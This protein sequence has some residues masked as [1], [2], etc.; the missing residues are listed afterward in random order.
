MA[1]RALLWLMAAAL[2][3]APHVWRAAVEVNETAARRAAIWAAAG[4]PPAPTAAGVGVLAA[5]SRDAHMLIPPAGAEQERR[6]QLRRAADAD[7]VRTAPSI[8][9]TRG[10]TIREVRAR[11]KEWAAVARV[12]RQKAPCGGVTAAAPP[13]AASAAT[14]TAPPPSAGSAAPSPLPLTMVWPTEAKRWWSTELAPLPAPAP[15]PRPQHAQR[16]WSAPPGVGTARGAAHAAGGGARTRQSRRPQTAAGAGSRGA[17]PAW[18]RRSTELVAGSAGE[19]SRRSPLRAAPVTRD[20]PPPR[21]ECC[22]PHPQRGHTCVKGAAQGRGVLDGDAAVGAAGVPAAG[23]GG[24]RTLWPCGSRVATAAAT[25]GAGTCGEGPRRASDPLTPLTPLTP[26]TIGVAAPPSRAQGSALGGA[27]GGARSPPA[28]CAR[29]S[30]AC[31]YVHDE[32]ERKWAERKRRRVGATA[33]A[34]AAC[35]ATSAAAPEQP[36]VDSGKAAREKKRRKKEKKKEKKKKKK[37]KRKK[38]E[39]K[40]MKKEQKRERRLKRSQA[41][42]L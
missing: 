2:A 23:G 22:A 15:A 42:E 27:F 16:P 35:G 18:S 8:E 17:A 19:R 10:P 26:D 31:T 5:S 33:A 4:W 37:K 24:A 12:L 6:G 41:R 20:A 25:C 39:K 38:K 11:L 40:E 32:R 13:G 1:R 30:S 9:Q 28:L 34:D 36:V 14:P 21:E 3:A 7:P 29:P